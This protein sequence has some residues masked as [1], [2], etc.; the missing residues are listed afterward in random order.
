[1]STD[2][3]HHCRPDSDP[4]PKPPVPDAAREIWEQ[5]FDAYC[6]HYFPRST[7]HEAGASII[8]RALDEKDREIAELRAYAD[9]LADG[10]P[11]GMLPKDVEVLREANHGLAKERDTLRIQ[12]AEQKCATDF[13]NLAEEYSRERAEKAEAERDTLRAEVERLTKR[14][15]H[16]EN[17]GYDGYNFYKIEEID[18]LRAERDAYCDEVDSAKHK[19]SAAMKCDECNLG[20]LVADIITE[21]NALRHNL[22]TERG[23]STLRAKDVLALEAQ[24][25]AKDREIAKLV[26]SG[27]EGVFRQTELR[28]RANAAEAE[29]A[30]AME[31]LREDIISARIIEAE[32]KQAGV[33][34][35]GITR[36]IGFIINRCTKAIA[37]IDAARKEGGAK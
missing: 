37:A 12:L 9:K 34:R 25:A 27:V 1:M 11:E 7:A 17:K 33:N 20:E 2:D 15:Y 13:A 22:D 18:Q 29:L 31:V 19:L 6:N 16:W 14:L 23:V 10:L 28:A 4:A 26:A 32:V 5:A 30:T 3:N 24:L 35:H 36:D 21:R 8:Q